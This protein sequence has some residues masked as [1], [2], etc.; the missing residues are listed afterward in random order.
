MDTDG[1]NNLNNIYLYSLKVYCESLDATKTKIVYVENAHFIGESW[2]K[3]INKFEI[4]YLTKNDYKKVIV[5]N[6]GNSIIVGIN[7]LDYRNGK[8]SVGIVPFSATYKKRK[9]HL[10]NGG[11][12]SVIFE[13][14]SQNKGFIYKTNEWNG[15]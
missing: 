14:D 1:L 9:V 2:P 3:K 12:L 15:I 7:N 4:Y 5:E 8:F 10:L 11:G 13:Y 6:N